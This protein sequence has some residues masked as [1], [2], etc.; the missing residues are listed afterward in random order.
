MPFSARMLTAAAALLCAAAASA[1]ERDLAIATRGETSRAAWRDL[2]FAP[3]TAA[4]DR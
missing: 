3:L 2:M 4:S 1:A